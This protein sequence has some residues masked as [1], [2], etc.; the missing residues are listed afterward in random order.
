MQILKQLF[1][2]YFHFATQNRI[3]GSLLAIFAVPKDQ[4]NYFFCFLF[5]FTYIACCHVFGLLI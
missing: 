1:S 2:I 3:F 4:K 5:W